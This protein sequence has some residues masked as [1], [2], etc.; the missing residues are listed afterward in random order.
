MASVTRTIHTGMVEGF[1]DP[2]GLGTV[3][4]DDGRRYG[5]HCTAIADGSTSVCCAPRPAAGRVASA[6]FGLQV[7]LSRCARGNWRSRRSSAPTVSELSGGGFAVETVVPKADVNVLI[8]DLKDKGAT[9]IIE[10]PLS[11]IVH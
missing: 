11:K 5:F 8:P 3:L 4:D 6:P 7:M 2:R 9:D 1:D 10:L